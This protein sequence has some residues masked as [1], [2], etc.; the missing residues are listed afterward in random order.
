MTL[1]A[2][3]SEHNC[4]QITWYKEHFASTKSGTA[5][6]MLVGRSLQLM[7]ISLIQVKYNRLVFNNIQ[8]GL[9][10]QAYHLVKWTE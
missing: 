6:I 5:C 8:E 7:D 4:S 1:M 2:N 9:Q 3:G 10:N